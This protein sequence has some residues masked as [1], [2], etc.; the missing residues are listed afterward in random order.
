V[1]RTGGRTA[2]AFAS[3]RAMTKVSWVTRDT[4][5]P[6]RPATCELARPLAPTRNREADTRRV[7]SGGEQQ[8]AD[9]IRGQRHIIHRPQVDGSTVR[10]FFD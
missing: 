4:E 8:S 6:R 2:T 5:T 3:T 7:G 10:R 1:W 9:G